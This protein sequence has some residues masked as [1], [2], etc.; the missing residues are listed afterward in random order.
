MAA[1]LN[2]ADLADSA[3]AATQA[4]NEETAK[5]SSRG[6]LVARRFFRNKLALAGL[7]VILL[8][9]VAAFTYTWYTPW[10]YDELD[11]MATLM[12]P[13]GSHWF[14]T[15]QIGGDMFAQTMR[16]LQKSLTIGLLAALFS[17]GVA[18][19]VGAAAG[20]FGGWTDRISMWVVDLLLIL[21]PFLIISILSP[22]FRGK[23]WLILVGL[24]ALF[25]WMITARIVRGMTLTL[26]EREF[27][28]AAKF[29]GQSPWRIIFK[30][31]VPN[32]ASLL[33][34]DATINVGVAII[35][36]TSLSFFG[37]GVQAPDVSLGTLI[38]T[39]SDAVRTFPWLFYIPAGFLVFTVL[40]V[41]FVGDG[42]RDALD[43][44]SSRSRRKER[45]RIQE[46]TAKTSSSSAQTVGA[47]A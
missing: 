20:Y 3:V 17:T 22:A 42:L 47:E 16:G 36:E 23:T 1:P 40:A 18:S 13:D 6:K 34:I 21:P 39:G 14:G 10:G 15:N 7:V 26:R 28:K 44:S 30:H 46:N 43:P 45:K 8:F 12:P 38:S 19:I 41:N 37:F 31:I 24:I 33:I 2:E 5:S 11:S 32:M 9:Y 29:M 35:T 27:V 25:Q 4:E